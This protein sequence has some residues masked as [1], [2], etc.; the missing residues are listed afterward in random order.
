MKTL[1]GIFLIFIILFTSCKKESIPV[2]SRPQKNVVQTAKLQQA[3]KPLTPV[4]AQTEFT[5]KTLADTLPEIAGQNVSNSLLYEVMNAC[6]ADKNVVAYHCK[7]I[8]DK[9]DVEAHSKDLRYIIEKNDSMFSRKDQKNLRAYTEY[10]R[11]DFRLDPS[12]IKDYTIINLSKLREEY[13]DHYDQYRNEVAKR[14]GN[15]YLDIYLP[16][17][18]VKK[19][20]AIMAIGYYGPERGEGKVFILK[21]EASGWKVVKIVPSWRSGSMR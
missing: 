19:D 21:K 3:A 6:L 17:F 2:A 20:Y 4:E 5:T 11:H 10:W 14:Y 13:G 15:K 7:F 9:Q 1:L 12:R 8:N 16:T 18:S